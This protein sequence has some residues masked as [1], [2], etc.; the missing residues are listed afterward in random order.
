MPP[1]RRA[2][3]KGWVVIVGW[4][5]CLTLAG[6]LTYTFIQALT[7]DPGDFDPV[8]FSLQTAASFLFLL[9]SVKLRNRVFIA[10]NGVALVN[11]VGTL[12]TI[13]VK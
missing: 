3:D 12:V 13:A 6:S 9:Y 4:V 8:F 10:A 5:A 2:A 7:S 1:K 11:A